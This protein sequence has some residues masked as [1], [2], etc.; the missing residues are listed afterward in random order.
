LLAYRNGILEST[1]DLVWMVDVERFGLVFFNS[2]L[3]RYFLDGAGLDIQIGMAPAD[4]LPPPR[5]AK[6]VALYQRALAEG[7]YNTEYATLHGGQVLELSAYPVHIDNQW[8][9]LPFGARILPSKNAPKTPCVA[10]N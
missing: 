10:A 1:D 5:A 4:M 6:W 8:W 7:P 3:H 9:A 2:A